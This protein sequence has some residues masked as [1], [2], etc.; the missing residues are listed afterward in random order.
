MSESTAAESLTFTKL[1]ESNFSTW[2]YD[3][4]AALQTKR[5]WRLV[6]GQ[7]AKPTEPDK[8]EL[9]NERAEQAAGL[10]YQKLE[11]GMQILV[12]QHMDNPIE[13]WKALQKLHEQDNPAARFNAFDEFFNISKQKDETLQSLVSRVEHALHKIRSTRKDTLTLSQFEEELAC[14]ALVRALPEEFSSFRSALLLLATFDL[15]TLKEAF[16]QEQI[17]PQKHAAE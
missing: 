1:G 4:Q 2:K 16:I 14:M 11:H 5:L 12:Q 15:K 13:M 7:E 3:M 17:N 10:I 6:S 9:W 8:L